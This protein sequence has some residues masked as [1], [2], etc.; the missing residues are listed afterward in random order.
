M[1]AQEKLVKAMH[2]AGIACKE[3]GNRIHLLSVKGDFPRADHY[4]EFDH[5][6]R[7]VVFAQQ[8]D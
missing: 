4:I 6:G 8:K 3:D 1:N 2:A 5:R 7:A